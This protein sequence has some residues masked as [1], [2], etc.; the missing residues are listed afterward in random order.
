MAIEESYDVEFEFNEQ[1]MLV[2]PDSDPVKMAKDYMAECER[3][4]AEYLASP[5]YK[6]QKEEEERKSMNMKQN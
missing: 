4:H 5:E 2:M 1:K 6:R 3:R